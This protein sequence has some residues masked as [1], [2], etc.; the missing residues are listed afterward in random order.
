MHE[1]WLPEHFYIDHMERDLPAGEVI[2]KGRK[3]VLVRC[4]DDTLAEILSDANYY[5]D[6]ASEG[7][8]LGDHHRAL[9]MQASARATVRRI[10]A[11][12]QGG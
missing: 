3:G 1:I 6:C 9:G 2:D 12:R 11:Y 5:S 10:K 7:W 8:D 4:D